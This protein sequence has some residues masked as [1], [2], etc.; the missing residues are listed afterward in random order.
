MHCTL[1]S[2]PLG[3]TIGPISDQIAQ[4]VPLPK[5]VTLCYCQHHDNRLPVI[6][7]ETGVIAGGEMNQATLPGPTVIQTLGCMTFLLHPSI[8][9]SGQ[10]LT[11]HTHRVVQKLSTT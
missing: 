4:A 5:K 8:S 6:Q 2:K 10:M 3:Q 9:G 7:L 1:R 11:L